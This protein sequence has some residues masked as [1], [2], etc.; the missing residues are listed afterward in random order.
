MTDPELQ[1]LIR[2]ERWYIL[3]DQEVYRKF[4]CAF[5]FELS[6]FHISCHEYEFSFMISCVCD[7]EIEPKASHMPGKHS[8]SEPKVSP[9]SK[10][11]LY[12]CLSQLLFKMPQTLH[13]RLSFLN[14]LHVLR[15]PERHI[16]WN[17]RGHAVQ[18]PALSRIL[19]CSAHHPL[20][21][22]HW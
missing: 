4:K 11:V 8:T 22:F 12:C 7:T 5:L 16:T 17:L 3:L 21:R 6:F 20:L 18:T 10:V 9:S 14:Y 1:L 15:E 2:E 19:C 13:L